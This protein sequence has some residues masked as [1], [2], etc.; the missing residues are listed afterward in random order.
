[1][2]LPKLG[3]DQ[4]KQRQVLV[5]WGLVSSISILLISLI[6]FFVKQTDAKAPPKRSYKSDISTATTRISPQETWMEQVKIDNGLQL[7]R[8]ETLEKSLE[9]LL[10]LNTEKPSV[11]VEQTT[12]V[13]E[14][15]AELKQSMLPPPPQELPMAPGGYPSRGSHPMVQPTFR[16][17]GIQKMSIN[18]VN[19]HQDKPLKTIDNYIPAGSF[20]PAVVLEGVDASTA[21]NSQGDPRP[22]TLQITEDAYLPSNHRS[23]LKGC[24]VTAAAAGDM[25]SERAYVRLEKLSC[26][27]KKTGEVIELTIKG[28]LVGGDSKSGQRGRLVDR[29]G[30]LMRNAAVGGFLSGAAEFMSQNRNPIKFLPSGMAETT[31]TPTADLLGQGLSKGASSALEKYAEYYIKRAEQMQPILEVASGQ[32]VSVMFTEGFS[33]SDSLTRS[34]ISKINDSKR[35]QQLNEMSETDK[36][37]EAW[38]PNGEQK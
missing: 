22:I 24:F 34:T 3:L 9:Q 38:L 8:L 20:A 7:K 13:A 16:S 35:Y 27:E 33:L 17:N 26:V 6:I 25:S 19:S 36:P 29:T 28:H 37:V 15:K 4:I 18:L 10:K 21:I 31:T 14:L 32:E 5:F 11:A 12:P 30:P 2:K 23:K 1:M